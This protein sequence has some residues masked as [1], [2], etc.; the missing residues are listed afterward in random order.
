[1]KIELIL[2][3]LKELG[4]ATSDVFFTDY[5]SSYR[6]M[7]RRL[8]GKEY[9]IENRKNRKQFEQD[10]H[11]FYNLLI[12]LSKQGFVGKKEL[13]NKKT[14]WFLTK[15]GLVKL[16]KLQI[17]K[18]CAG[19]KITNNEKD[20]WKIITFDVPEKEKF[21]RSWLRSQLIILNFKM[22]QKSVWIGDSKLPEKFLEDLKNLGL[23]RCIHI[24]GVSKNGTLDLSKKV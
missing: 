5:Y 7:Y 21:K 4:E 17:K 23:F 8:Y 15:T 14:S 19:F 1:M 18:S 12:Y 9:R 3:S 22:L 11:K 16:G 24:F 10:R 2:Q 13:S 20:F 6:N